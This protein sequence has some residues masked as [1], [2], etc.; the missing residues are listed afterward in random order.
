MPE[1]KKL[2]FVHG[3]ATDN[4]VWEGTVNALGMDA[5]NINLPGHGGKGAWKEPNLNPAVTEIL[6]NAASLGGSVIG[7]GWS[8]GAKALISAAAAQPESFKA[9]VLVG[10]GASFVKR[11]GYE[12][13]QS[14]ALVKRMIMDM[15]KDPAETVDRFYPLNFTEEELKSDTVKRFIARYRYPGPITCEGDVPG[16][17]PAFKYDEITTALEALYNADLREDIKRIKIPT[18]IIHG[19]K[20]G[21]CPVEAGRYL[22][23]SI[24]SSQLIEFEGAGHAPFL[25]DERFNKILKEYIDEA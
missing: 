24:K 23:S 17:F 11:E 7:I 21:I 10:A 22:S 18:L 19:T 9:L 3:W 2:L 1:P 5:R 13:G 14:K 6:Q 25:T 15:R 16:C 20:D 12:W 8:L 4:W